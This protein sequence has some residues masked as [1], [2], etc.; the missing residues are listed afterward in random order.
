MALKQEESQK[1]RLIQ[2]IEEAI[3]DMS[4]LSDTVKNMEELVTDSSF[5]KVTWS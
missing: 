3:R 2:M 5:L 1:I 4:A